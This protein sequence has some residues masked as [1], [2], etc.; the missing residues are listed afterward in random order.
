M[1]QTTQVTFKWISPRCFGILCTRVPGLLHGVVCVILRLPGYSAGLWRTDR[2]T[3][4]AYT[5]LP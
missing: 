1:F 4:T 5:A 2:H 3:T